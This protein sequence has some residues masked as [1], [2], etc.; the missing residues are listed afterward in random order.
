MMANA[1]KLR[2]KEFFII[3]RVSMKQV[4][5]LVKMPQ[6]ARPDLKM[7]SIQKLQN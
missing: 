1:V 7:P 6:I 2:L 3:G 5:T 4:I